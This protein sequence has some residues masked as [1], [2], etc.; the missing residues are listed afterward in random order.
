MDFSSEMTLFVKII[1]NVSTKFSHS[2]CEHRTVTN[3]LVC[4]IFNNLIES[5]M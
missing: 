1:F 5:Y 2:Y 3:E 4:K